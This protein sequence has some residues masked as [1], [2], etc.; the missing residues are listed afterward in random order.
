MAPVCG[1]FV[2]S[3]TFCQLAKV[4]TVSSAQATPC[5][6]SLLAFSPLVYF[7]PPSFPG[8]THTSILTPP[9]KAWP[10]AS[11][12]GPSHTPSNETLAG[13]TVSASAPWHSP[14]HCIAQTRQWHRCAPIG[15]RSLGQGSESTC[16]TPQ[17]M[18]HHCPGPPSDWQTACDSQRN[19]RP[20]G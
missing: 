8:P 15:A 18:Q 14:R 4:T 19:T 7:Q 6:I 10:M 3:C 1:W 17:R 16:G 9:M 2:R 13:L 20:T 5:Y 11:F 12:P